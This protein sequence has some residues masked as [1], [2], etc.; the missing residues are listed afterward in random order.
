MICLRSSA[1]GS[2]S[3]THEPYHFRFVHVFFFSFHLFVTII[4]LQ[5]TS[6]IYT[7]QWDNLTISVCS[8]QARWFT[9]HISIT[10]RCIE[11]IKSVGSTHFQ[12]LIR[13]FSHFAIIYKTYIATPTTTAIG[14]IHIHV[15]SAL[16]RMRFIESSNFAVENT[17]RH[18]VCGVVVVA[19]GQN[20]SKTKAPE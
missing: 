3:K 10:I 12:S 2:I 8:L 1:C 5:C 9:L 4:W 11:F 19:I 20:S 18:F 6:M 14:D 13:S 16:F 15:S 7:F 17:N